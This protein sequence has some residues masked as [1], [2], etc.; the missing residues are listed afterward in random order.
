MFATLRK[1]S[2]SVLRN[3]TAYPDHAHYG[4]E[5]SGQRHVIEAAGVVDPTV[6][7]C[8][9]HIR[10]NT[11]KRGCQEIDAIK[12]APRPLG[13]K[14]GY[15][16]HQNEDLIANGIGNIEMK[17]VEVDSARHQAVGKNAERVQIQGIKNQ[18]RYVEQSEGAESRIV[19]FVRFQRQRRSQWH[20]FQ[21][22]KNIRG[23]NVGN[24]PTKHNLVRGPEAQAGQ[25]HETAERHEQPK[26]AYMR[27]A[28]LKILECQNRRS[29]DKND[30]NAIAQ[31]N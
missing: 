14:Q 24:L 10:S 25:P 31:N 29:G 7:R 1:D 12:T 13:P 19:S 3:R 20:Q 5:R 4:S 16:S 6:A 2:L 15:S 23:R 22:K 9:G 17:I 26:T 21:E 18:N 28:A 8:V 11:V 30:L 27:M